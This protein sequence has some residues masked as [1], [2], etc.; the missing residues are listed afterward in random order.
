MTA[1]IEH[2]WRTELGA[3]QSTKYLENIQLSDRRV[4]NYQ[5]VEYP[6]TWQE[7][8]GLLGSA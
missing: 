5:V 4:F 8:K 7:I 6:T 1:Q 2:M 3:S